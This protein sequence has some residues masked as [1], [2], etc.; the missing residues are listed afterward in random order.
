[1]EH[2][3][4]TNSVPKNNKSNAIITAITSTKRQPGTEDLLIYVLLL[5]NYYVMNCYFAQC[6]YYI[7]ISL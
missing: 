7:Y 5:H 6:F 1:M 4:T 3:E 2:H